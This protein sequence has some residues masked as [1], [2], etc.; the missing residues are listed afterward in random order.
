MKMDCGHDSEW[1]NWEGEDAWCQL[2]YEEA[3]E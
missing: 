3:L 2:C 1:L